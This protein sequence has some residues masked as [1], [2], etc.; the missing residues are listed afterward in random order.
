MTKVLDILEDYCNGKGFACE[1]IDGHVKGSDRQAGIDRFSKKD[2]NAFIF[3]L[4]TKAGGVGINLTA[5]DTV[6]RTALTC[7][8][9]CSLHS[10]LPRFLL[11]FVRLCADHL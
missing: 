4:C 2:S 10:S 6:V 9:E 8:A 3:L 1:R 5:A 11:L 7:N